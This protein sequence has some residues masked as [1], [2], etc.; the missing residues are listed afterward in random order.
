M[1]KRKSWTKKQLRI[2]EAEYPIAKNTRVLA[3][4]IGKPYSAMRSKVTSL[5]LHRV[6]A[7]SGSSNATKR[8]LKYI[9]KNYLKIPLKRIAQDLGNGRTYT[10]VKG[11][12]DALG[13]VRPGDLIEKIKSDS[14][15]KKGNVP[16]NKGRKQTDYMSSEG[17]DNSKATRFKKGEPN[18]NS[19]YD[20][21][22]TIRHNHKE[23]NEKPHKYIRIKKGI[24]KE[25][26]IYNWEQING[27][28][29]KGFVLACIDG[30]TLNCNP[31]NWELMSM[32]DNVKRNSGS[33]NLADGYIAK[34]IVGKYG[35]RELFD[36]VKKNPSLIKLKRQQLLLKRAINES[37]A[38]TE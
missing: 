21:A 15:I 20:G 26:Q 3:K 25:L 32:A 13:L 9:M 37:A 30:D 36:I 19:L 7:N 14:L 17:I 33:L 16:L 22:I 38:N 11:R 5:K 12:M 34:V 31:S 6:I 4:K 24:W 2:L 23:R 18:H 28:V 8:E 27:R 29:P 1:G 35:D 10:F